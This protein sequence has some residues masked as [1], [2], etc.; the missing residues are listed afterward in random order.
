MMSNRR[1]MKNSYLL[2]EYNRDAMALM[3]D[4][5]DDEGQIQRVRSEQVTPDLYDIPE[6]PKP[7]IYAELKAPTRAKLNKTKRLLRTLISNTD[8]LSSTTTSS[9]T[10]TKLLPNRQS[11]RGKKTKLPVTKQTPINSTTT[12]VK[13]IKPIIKQPRLTKSNLKQLN[14]NKT[15]TTTSTTSRASTL[16]ADRK[17][18]AKSRDSKSTRHDTSDAQSLFRSEDGT[19]IVSRDKDHMDFLNFRDEYLK[20]IESLLITFREREF[21]SKE[22]SNSPISTS[23]RSTTTSNSKMITSMKAALSKKD[24]LLKEFK[25]CVLSDLKIGEGEFGETF[26]GYRYDLGT[27]IKIAAKRLKTLKDRDQND[28]SSLNFFAEISVLTQLDKHDHVIEYLGVHKWES[29]MYIIFEYAEKGD[30]KHLL[31][32]C[33]KN[34]KRELH[35]SGLFKLKMAYEIASGMEYIHSLDIVHKDLA[36]RN[37]LLDKDFSCKV[38]DF[39]CCKNEFLKKRPIRW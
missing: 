18:S 13:P 33:R 6:R 19:S 2:A 7:N 35:L 10:R 9:I 3:N 28:Q 12:T 29:T 39:G 30:L 22:T 32:Q 20:R 24:N 21:A 11:E 16:L 27:P 23:R 8:S 14:A 36:A 5:D 38:A 26:Q 31:D 15:T 25:Y 34:M 1:F 17:K 37:I 4:T